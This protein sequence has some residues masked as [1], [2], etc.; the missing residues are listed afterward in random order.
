[1]AR[2]EQ[3]SGSR[4]RG[5]PESTDPSYEQAEG[6]R[7]NLHRQADAQATPETEDQ[8]RAVAERTG[9][10]GRAIGA[11]EGREP[12]MDVRDDADRAYQES[13]GIRGERDNRP[14]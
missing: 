4:P 1:M 7:N 11:A 14:G 10:A 8:H 9:N 12:S 2:D 6:D 3:Q 5:G 13:R